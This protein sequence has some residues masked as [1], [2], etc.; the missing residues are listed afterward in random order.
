MKKRILSLLLAAVMLTGT[1]TAAGAAVVELAPDT[2]EV[3][4]QP[5]AAEPTEPASEVA[6]EAA[7]AETEPAA[8]ASVI[9]RVQPELA[10]TSASIPAIT[11]IAPSA[12]GLKLSWTP[13]DDADKY[14][15]FLRRADTGGWKK[16]GT[17]TATS[18]D[19]KGLVNDTDYTYTV[20]GTNSRGSFVTDY[21]REGATF[22]YFAIP[23]MT[24]IESTNGGQKLYWDP[25]DGAEFYMVY[26]KTASGWIKAGTTETPYCINSRVTSGKSYTYTVRCWDL[27][28]EIPLSYYNTK[29]FSGVYIGAPQITAFNA[30]KDGVT[31]SWD[32]VD[33]AAKYA[34][35]RKTSS[36][37]RR[38]GVTDKTSYS[39][40]GLKTGSTYTYT[41]RCMNSGNQYISGYNTRGKS[42]TVIKPP[43]VTDVSYRQLKYT[44]K[45]NMQRSAASYRVYRK[46]L[47][48]KWKYLGKSD[49]D[50]FTDSTAKKTGVYTYTVRSMDANDNYL[51]YYTDTEKYY[52][53]GLFII[54]LNDSAPNTYP[55]YTCE[56][57]ED[58]LRTIVART[59]D[60]WLGA[61]EGDVYHRDIL[62]YYNTYRPLAVDYSMQLHDAWCA[63]FTSAVWIRT[64]VAPYIGTECGCG[65]FIDVAKDHNIW[66][67]SD[68]Y[69]PK[70]GDAIIYYW[71]DSGVGELT[72][73][74]DHIGIVTA[75]NG[76]DFVVTEGNTGTG[77]VGQHDRVVNGRF[78]RGYIA[79]N[80]ALIAQYLSLR[81]RI[82][83]S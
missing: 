82:I 10:P 30:I 35:F 1:V 22:H 56:V 38:I 11:R 51:T 63:A 2:A 3:T 75:V 7:A 19:H 29:G 9:R 43:T 15:V 70:V 31:I 26:I 74:A 24:R 49:T 83:G 76:N 45:W 25:V 61:V 17:T 64:G 8:E 12:N 57:T 14:I 52:S 6:T 32:A 66:V 16:L 28:D 39:H 80:Y 78:I 53:M 48:G 59:A 72:H 77:Y 4:E 40:T 34:V 41:V 42:F 68:G 37:W 13:S 55:H 60:G 18:F 58:E 27:N 44:V 5:T 69:V 23:R 33:G 71:S 50:S 73:G 54:G 65:R 47:G 21:D 67:E 46:E 79:P 36:G 20:R 62:R 81:A